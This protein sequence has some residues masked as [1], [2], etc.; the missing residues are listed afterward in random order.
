MSLRGHRVSEAEAIFDT[1]MCGMA[2]EKAY[3]VYLLANYTNSDDESQ[4]GAVFILSLSD[5]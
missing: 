3:C 5:L 1:T 2:V 4:G